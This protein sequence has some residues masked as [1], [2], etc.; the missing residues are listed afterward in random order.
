MAG[1]DTRPKRLPRRASAQ[2]GALAHGT[3]PASA[4]D[5]ETSMGKTRDPHTRTPARLMLHSTLKQGAIVA[6]IL[7]AGQAVPA[8]ARTSILFIGNS[9]TYGE[10]AGGLPT[11]M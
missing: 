7:L 2:L 3:R 5:L 10:P 1:A 11:V 8:L 4:D 6:A 9:F